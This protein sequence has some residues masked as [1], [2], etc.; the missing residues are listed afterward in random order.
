MP[1]CKDTVW[2]SVVKTIF[3]KIITTAITAAFTGIG[4]AVAIH[5]I[6]TAVYLIYERVWNKISWGRKIIPDNNL[7]NK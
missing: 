3:F 6:L 1:N 2:R 4:K 5:L 7:V